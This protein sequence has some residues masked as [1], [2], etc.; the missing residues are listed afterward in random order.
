VRR[1][2]GGRQPSPS[3]PHG[4]PL[5]DVYARATHFK[6]SAAMGAARAR[7]ACLW[8]LAVHASAHAAGRGAPMLVRGDAELGFLR[9][10]AQV[11]DHG[12]F[13]S[14]RGVVHGG[15]LTLQGYRCVGIGGK[16]YL[17][18]RLICTAW[19]GP[20][21][22]RKHTHVCH[23]DLDPSNSQPDNLAWATPG[24]KNRR[25][26][27]NNPNR[28]SNAGARSK[29]V[30]GREQGTTDEWTHFESC[31]AAGRAR[32]WAWVPWREH[33]G[34]GESQT[35]THARLD[36]RVHAAVRGDRGRAVAD[37]R[38]G[39]SRERRAGVRPRPLP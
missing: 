25:S 30:R 13:R 24:D 19:H 37:C 36:V 7:L 1:W 27:V 22:T 18:H 35:D 12:R 28:K 16:S 4:R 6:K 3:A 20:P 34:G 5:Y 26:Y 21:P 8:A 15:A 9:R 39:R 10:A 11:S 29:P 2:T 14:A 31:A 33:R 38:V 23:K 32:A 17:L